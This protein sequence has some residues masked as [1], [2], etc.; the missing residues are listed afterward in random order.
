MVTTLTGII[1]LGKYRGEGEAHLL[2]AKNLK[3]SGE[4]ERKYETGIHQI[5]LIDIHI[6]SKI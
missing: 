5:L 6:C 4:G 3:D 2:V 1:M